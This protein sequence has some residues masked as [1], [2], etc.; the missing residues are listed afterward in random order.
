MKTPKQDNALSR[1]TNRM[2]C[3]QKG[4]TIDKRQIFKFNSF[5][6]ACVCIKPTEC[7]AQCTQQK[8]LIIDKRRIFNFYSVSLYV[9]QNAKLQL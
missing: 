6:R 4:L 9:Y 3:C 7:I 8:G 2:H 1:L 5:L